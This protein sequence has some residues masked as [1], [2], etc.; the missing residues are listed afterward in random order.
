[1]P[2]QGK[3]IRPVDQGQDSS[4]RRGWWWPGA[5]QSRRQGQSGRSGLQDVASPS[6]GK[7]TSR[8]CDPFATLS[9]GHGLASSSSDRRDALLGQHLADFVPPIPLVPK[10]RGRRARSLRIPSASVKSLHCPSRRGSRRG[11]PLLWQ[12]PWSVLIMPP[13]CHQSGGDQIPLVEAGRRG[14][15]F[16]IS[17][18]VNHQD[19]WVWGIR[20]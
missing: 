8:F 18:G 9:C 7:R 12:T 16:G 3:P 2:G 5:R 17:G 1:M 6:T 10:H 13:W 14:M 20:C 19:L 11:P 4:S 15:S